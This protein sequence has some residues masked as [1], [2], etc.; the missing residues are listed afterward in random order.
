MEYF[1]P[2]TPADARRAVAHAISELVTLR[3]VGE[4]IGRDVQGNLAARHGLSRFVGAQHP[5]PEANH[6]E[7]ESGLR[8]AAHVSR[9]L[10]DDDPLA[11]AHRIHVALGRDACDRVVLAACEVLGGPSAVMPALL[12]P[13]GDPL[14]APVPFKIGGRYELRLRD[15]TLYPVAATPGA[16]HF[17]DT[18][19]KRCY[20]AADAKRILLAADPGRGAVA[21]VVGL[22]LV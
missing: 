17:V 15:R 18:N 14:D 10:R 16:L 20:L 5:V 2:S 12:D 7:T 13:D 3:N 11:L 19:G 8:M 6:D 22:V 9:L 21:V 4:A 1:A